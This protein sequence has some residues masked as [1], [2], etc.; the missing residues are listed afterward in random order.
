[1]SCFTQLHIP[2]IPMSAQAL[3]NASDTTGQGQI[4]NTLLQLEKN[5][6]RVHTDQGD[7]EVPHHQ[8]V[9]CPNHLA[10]QALISYINGRARAFARTPR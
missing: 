8:S 1:M 6:W 5:E 3:R 2:G 7:P 10:S 4:T 9:P